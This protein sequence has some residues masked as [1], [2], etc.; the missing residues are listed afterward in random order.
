[1]K[2]EWQTRRVVVEVPVLGDYSE[3]DLRWDIARLVEGSQLNRRNPQ[4]KVVFGTV[5]VKEFARVDTTSQRKRNMTLM[6]RVTLLE[7]KVS[8]S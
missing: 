1:M 6:E 4:I 5:L 2:R 7:K 8:Q 3:K